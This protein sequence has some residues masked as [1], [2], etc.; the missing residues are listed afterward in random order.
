MENLTIWGTKKCSI[1]PVS[2]NSSDVYLKSS[3]EFKLNGLQEVSVSPVFKFFEAR[4]IEATEWRVSKLISAEVSLQ[5]ASFPVSLWN[6]LGCFDSEAREIELNIKFSGTTDGGK[7]ETFEFYSAYLD[8][9]QF[10]SESSKFS[11]NSLEFVCFRRRLDEEIWR[12]SSMP[13]D[14]FIDGALATL[15]VSYPTASPQQLTNKIDTGGVGYYLILLR[16]DAPVTVSIH[17]G[18]ASSNESLAVG[19]DKFIAPQEIVFDNDDIATV[20]ARKQAFSFGS[21]AIFTIET[22]ATW[23]NIEI[24]LGR[25]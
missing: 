11:T 12:T 2:I 21:Q 22:D 14:T 17:E 8:S 20:G 23:V 3:D 18:S 7:D 15:P 24:H 13:D 9:A 10:D 16:A 4:S 6:R 5:I 25:P 19:S 1:T